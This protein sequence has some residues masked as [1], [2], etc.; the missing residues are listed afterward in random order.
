MKSIKG[1]H[2]IV[3]HDGAFGSAAASGDVGLY[4]HVPFC[5]KL[6]HYCDFNTYL[7]RDGGVDDYLA[8]LGREVDLYARRADVAGTTFTTV[9][10]G[11]G[12]PTALTAP[13]L[14]RLLQT[15][16]RGFSIAADAE[17][18]VEANPGTLIDSRLQALLAGGVNRLSIG[19]QS[20]NDDLLHT[21]GRIHTARQALDC[22]ERAR[23]LGFAN[24]SIDLMF[25]L[26]G[27]GLS[28]WQKTLMEVASWSPDHLSCY[29]LI[30]EQGTPFGDLYEAGRLLLPTEED[31][32]AMYRFTMDH[33]ATRGY[34]H[35]EIANWAK[36]GKQSRHNR[37]YWLNGQWLG[38]GPGA[39]SQWRGERFANVKLPADYAR[40]TAEGKFP[41]ATTE[42]VT[43]PLAMEDTMMLGLRLRGGV[44]EDA[45]YDKFGVRPA[46]IFGPVIDE[47]IGFRLLTRDGGRLQLTD[48]G[49][50]VANQV[51]ER[52]IGV[53]AP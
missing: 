1:L 21:L 37:I 4:V 23:R 31:E 34:E 9:F 42:K 44:D 45:F 10:I 39:H 50:F 33:L 26:P 38:L 16:R 20:V 27:Q 35:Y 30:I 6:C 52:F 40:L 47:L 24:V 28:D 3:G 15:L 11:G 36:P 7:L 29:G 53:A 49:L 25:G 13:Q 43:K 12:T 2:G 48:A 17:I 19:V 41:V 18:T 14:E 8:A 22:Y 46:D 5:E 51:F 32:L